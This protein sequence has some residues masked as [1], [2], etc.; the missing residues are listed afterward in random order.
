MNVSSGLKEYEVIF[1]AAIVGM[2]KEEKTRVIRHLAEHMSPGA[3]LLLR[4]AHRTR[5]FLYLVI[6]P[7]DYLQGFEVLSM[8]HPTDEFINSVIIARKHMSPILSWNQELDSTTLP[9]KCSEIQCINPL[10]HGNIMKELA[11]DEQL[12]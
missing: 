11:I 6:D 3:F 12:L 9:R 5:A 4:S 10:S 7:C 8:F 2:D 1:L